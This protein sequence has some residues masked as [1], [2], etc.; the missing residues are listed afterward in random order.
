LASVCQPALE[1]A[2]KGVKAT[3]NML[4]LLIDELRAV[5]FLVGAENVQGLSEVP[6]VV[7][8]KTA[9]WLKARG[10]NVADYARRGAR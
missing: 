9:E 5:M 6:V 8:G 2:V 7:T 4:S 1:T 3:E 10:F